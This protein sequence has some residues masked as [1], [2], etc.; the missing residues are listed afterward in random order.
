MPL[1]FTKWLMIFKY[2]FKSFCVS[3]AFGRD[4][5]YRN[6]Q[7]A[8]GLRHHLHDSVLGEAVCTAHLL[9]CG[10]RETPFCFSAGFLQRK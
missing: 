4:L 1:A 7:A 3:W 6:S 5:V 10:S 9:I 8:E 2:A